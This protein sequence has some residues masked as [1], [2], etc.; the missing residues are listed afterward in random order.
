[1]SLDLLSSPL[2]LCKKP[3]VILNSVTTT[4][5]GLDLF[6]TQIDCRFAK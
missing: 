4:G 1:M 3:K 2:S 6:V 5:I